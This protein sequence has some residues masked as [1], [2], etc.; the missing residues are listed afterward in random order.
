MTEVERM[1]ECLAK[2]ADL[3]NAANGCHDVGDKH[4]ANGEDE[5]ELGMDVPGCTIKSLPKRLVIKGADNAIRINPVNAP[6]EPH[7]TVGHVAGT[8]MLP[9]LLK[10]GDLV[11]ESGHAVEKAADL[12]AV[13]FEHRGVGGIRRVRESRELLVGRCPLFSECRQ[14]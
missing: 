9:D 13:L 10:S 1:R 12:L 11:L 4:S 5:T 8:V 3:A 7:I 2:I 6:L 14:M